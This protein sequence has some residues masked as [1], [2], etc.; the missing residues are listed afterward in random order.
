MTRETAIAL[1]REHIDRER[2]I[3]QI[4]RIEGRAAEWVVEHQSRAR[5]FEEA[6]AIVEAIDG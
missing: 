1:L 2:Q 3:A 5:A 6:L 4:M